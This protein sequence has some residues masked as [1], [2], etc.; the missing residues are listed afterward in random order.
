MS[1]ENKMISQN[2]TFRMG[3]LENITLGMVLIP[4]TTVNMAG[5][6][7]FVALLLGLSF[8]VVY[9]VIIYCLSIRLPRDFQRKLMSGGL[10]GR[11]A[12]VIYSMRY[13]IRAGLIMLFFGKTMQEFLLQSYSLW[14]IIVVFALVCGYGAARDIEKRGRLLELL[15]PWMIIPI[16][17]VAVFSIS[18]IDL[19]ELY[20]GLMGVNYELL[21]QGSGVWDVILGGY[22]TFLI[23]TSTELMLFILPH[24]KEDNWRNTLKTG[25][26]I[27]IAIL[28]AYVFVIGILGGHWVSSDSQAA[29]NVMEAAFIPGEIITRAD[30]PVLAFWIIGVFAIISGYMFYAKEAFLIGTRLKEKKQGNIGLWLVMVA[31]VGLAFVWSGESTSLYLA[32]YM[33]WGDVAISIIFPLVFVIKKGEGMPTLKASRVVRKKTTLV[34]IFFMISGLMVGCDIEDREFEPVGE[35]HGSIEDRD[36]V[37]SITIK[38][39]EEIIFTVADIKKYLKDATGDYE[40]KEMSV[41]EDSLEDAL[42]EYY[43]AKGRWLD[44]GHL[45]T[46]TFQEVGEEDLREFAMEMGNIHELGKSVTATI[47]SN[48]ESEELPLRQLI[49]MAYSGEKL[50]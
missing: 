17:L 7:H 22:V 37:T 4:Y 1:L 28:L 40:T 26:W 20:R 8:T 30:Y 39:D 2:Q 23:L 35:N 38:G 12:S 14:I 5:K 32:K 3:I 15:Y 10:L 48:K 47:S 6:W 31:V 27:I 50:P 46:V 25:I 33:L 19:E 43:Q 42:E 11:T 18:S 16:I 24:Q 36:Y 49:K 34:L 9:M 29:L 13:V 41:K 45:S 44:L 21:G